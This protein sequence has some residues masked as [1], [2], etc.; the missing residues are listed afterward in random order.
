MGVY[1]I[2]LAGVIVFYV[3]VLGVGI[4]AAV[5]KKKKSRHGQDGMILANRGLGP[6]LGIFTLIATWVGGAYVNGTA[7]LMFTRGLAWCQVPFGYSLS[8]LFGAV[9]FVR[10]MR[11]AEHVTML[12]PFQERYGAG[13]GGLLFLPALCG[14]LFWCAAVLRALG[15]S[16]AVVAGVDPDISIVASAL[17]AA[18]YTVFG[19]LYAVACTDALQLACIIIGLGVS[20][21]FSVL[22]PAVSFEKN[23]APHEW[24]GEIKN[25]DLGEW[26]D[27]MLLL[28]F[29]GIP[30]QG[31]FQR[32]LSMRSTSMA[33]ALSIASMFGC[34]ILAFPSALIGVVARATDWS[35]I[36]GFNR[37]IIAHDGNAALPV[38]LRYLTPQW[39]SFV[40]LGAISAAVMSS[41]DS[42]ILASSSMFSRNV[43]RL[44]LRPKA[45]ERELNWILRISV[46]VITVLSTVIALTVDSVY[47]L[48]YLS[49][50]LVYVVLFPQLLTVVHWPSLVDTYGCLAG[51]FVAVVLRL[52]GGEKGL[53]V[54]ALIEYPFYDTETQS[55]KFPFRTGAMIVAL[56]T[57]LITSFFT[58][59]L[60]GKGYFPRCCDVL[61]V[62]SPGKSKDQS[63]VVQSSSGAALMDTSSVNKS[64]SGMDSCDGIGPGSYDDDRTTSNSVEDMTDRVD[65]GTIAGDPYEKD[66]TKVNSVGS[67]AQKANQS[68]QHLQILRNS[69]HTSSISGRHTPTPNQYAPIQ[70]NEVSKGQIL[71]VRNLRGSMG[72]IL[73]STDRP[74]ITPSNAGIVNVPTNPTVATPMTPG[75]H[76]TKPN[77]GALLNDK[78]RENERISIVDRGNTEFQIVPDNML[79][80]INVKKNVKGVKLVGMEGGTLRRPSLQGTFSPTPSVELVHILDRRQSSS[81]YGP[82]SLSPVPMGIEA[83]KTHG[84]AL[85]GQSGNEHC[86]IKRGIVRHHSLR[87][88]NDTGD[89]ALTTL[90][91]QPTYPSMPLRPE[92]CR[93]TLVKKDR[94]TSTIARH[95]SVTN[96]KELSGCT[97]GLVVC[98]PTYSMYSSAVKNSNY[99]VTDDEAVSRF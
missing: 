34:M 67:A 95:G 14:D 12:D 29:G 24:L 55:Q 78:T 47:Y 71:G 41:A 38:V 83:C 90:A 54:P 65:S 93:M 80:T 50:D 37:S 45:S 56:F 75:P 58:R 36:E 91:R 68:L 87:S 86:R 4:W 19:G 9:L 21:P 39:V 60:L 15:S 16:L 44:T 40:G 52:C 22:H 23:L 84:T 6:V 8:L 59:N 35:S 81:S 11:K 17:L 32:I 82:G 48:S 51:Y 99:F 5:V 97:T 30:W 10:P 42:S 63:G 61:S 20:A 94:R 89:R 31:Y 98:S 43:Y 92:D 13:V 25:E 28:V 88:F 76:Y 62:Y 85:E 3:A 2:G 46:V 26:V 79:T 7:E 73:L 53:G 27:C 57:Q 49:S 1:V 70:S 72:Q 69:I 64:T 18:M 77:D 96:E 66:T 74:A 33:T